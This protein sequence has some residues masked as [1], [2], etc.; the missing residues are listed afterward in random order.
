M[1]AQH[2]DKPATE[3]VGKVV[4]TSQIS[5][6]NYLT[7]ALVSYLVLDG[8]E[9]LRYELSKATEDYNEQT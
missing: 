8:S 3:T 1:Y 5:L 4:T 6:A 2:P 9:R 7:L